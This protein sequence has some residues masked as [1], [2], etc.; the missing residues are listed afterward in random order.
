[1]RRGAKEEV[2]IKVLGQL[3]EAPRDLPAL[4]SVECEVA[5]AGVVLTTE[6]VRRLGG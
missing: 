6:S 5:A 3:L 4:Q 2:E 1:M